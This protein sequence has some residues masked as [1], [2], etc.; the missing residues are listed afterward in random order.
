MSRDDRP[1]AGVL[2]AAGGG[3]RF[4]QA[5]ALV[6]FQGEPLV[7][8]GVRL[9]RCG[10]CDPVV[11]VVG[12]DGERV[13]EVLGARIDALVYNQ[14]WRTGMGGSLRSGLAV[15]RAERAPAA[16]VALVD[17]PLVSPEAIRR[18]VEAWRGGAIVAV[19]TYAGKARNPVL[20]DRSAWD[21]VDAAATGDRGARSLLRDRPEWVQP[22]PCDAVASALDIDTEDDLRALSLRPDPN[23]AAADECS[24]PKEQQW[25]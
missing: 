19:A 4:G 23:P 16:V 8:R 10:G 12:A 15:V 9:L 17:Q 13:A 7:C 6:R 18:L 25:N 22:V 3:R 24:A 11:V 1:P 2:L 20:F 21:A 14:R 5:K